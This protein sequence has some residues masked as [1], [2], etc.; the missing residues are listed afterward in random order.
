MTEWR[1]M[2]RESPESTGG[3]EA[4]QDC[5]RRDEDEGK[6]ALN[7]NRNTCSGNF[8][9]LNHFIQININFSQSILIHGKRED[10]WDGGSAWGR[11]ESNSISSQR[12]LVRSYVESRRDMEIYDIWTSRFHS[13]CSCKNHQFYPSMTAVSPA[14]ASECPAM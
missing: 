11:A 2:W 10:A 3:A 7:A 12:E 5:F 9:F 6:R 8:F 14:E 1:S 13:F 4:G